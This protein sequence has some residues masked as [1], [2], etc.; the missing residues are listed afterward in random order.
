MTTVV[1]SASRKTDIP[2][3]YGDWLLNRLD[4]GFCVMRN[5]FTRQPKRVSL[6]REDV[7]AFVFWTK[8]PKPF[9]PT[10]SK[11][12]RRGFPFYMHVTVTGFGAPMERSVASWE[13]VGDYCRRLVS[14]YGPRT[15][16]W[17]YDPIVITD[18]MTTDW[19]IE[20]FARLADVFA[21]I[22]DEVATSFVEPY[23]KVRSNLD[24]LSAKTGVRWRD[25]ALEEKRDL[26]RRL[27]GLGAERGML[28]RV[29]SQ[30]EVAGGLP[31]GRCID[32][33]RLRDVGASSFSSRSAPTRTGCNCI[34]S[35]DIGEYDTCPQGCAYCYAN[36]DQQTAARN[37]KEHDRMSSCL[38]GSLQMKQESDAQLRL[39]A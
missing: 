20:N 1:I 15:V 31:E 32:P 16:A 17:R 30:P 4:E 34:Q 3:F 8:N 12:A 5:T 14:E 24:R 28:L 26:V 7:D 35:I 22:S 33:V 38:D 21:G 23:R 37:L 2:A 19:H 39:I 29:C 25:P 6:A 11:I 9:L 36:R 10:L 27:S 18:S 13:S